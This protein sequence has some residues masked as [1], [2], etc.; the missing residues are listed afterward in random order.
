MN[1]IF[2]RGCVLPNLGD[3]ANKPL[4]EYLSGKK[5]NIVN[6]SFN[7]PVVDIYT[8]MG[9]VMGWADSQTTVWGTGCINENS[10]PKETPKR[11]LA[12]RGELTRS[13]LL[14]AGILCPEVYGDP[15]ILMPLVYKTNGV[16]KY[17]IGIIPHQIE[18]D[19]SPIIEK[20]F[21]GCHIIDVQQPVFNI[22]EEICGCE[23][24]ASSALHGIICADTYNVPAIWLKLSNKV[25]GNGFKF[26]DYFT[27]VK[28]EDKEP[29][30]YSEDLTIEDIKYKFLSWSKPRINIQPLLNSCPWRYYE[31]C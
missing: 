19:L 24:I 23:M 7:L 2:I 21:E 25:I 14:K 6:S 9:S 20:Q 10:L 3:S 1:E 26:L 5:V 18:K 4:V 28:R 29:L 22:V 11:I 31:S 27:S 30:I 16:K 12:V 13:I 8:V 15:F 17:K